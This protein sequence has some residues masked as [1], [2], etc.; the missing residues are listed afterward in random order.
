MIELSKVRVNGTN[1]DRKWELIS[2]STKEIE[3]ILFGK[4][5]VM[6]FVEK[7]KGKYMN[8]NWN[9]NPWTKI[10]KWLRKWKWYTRKRESESYPVAAQRELRLSFL[11]KDQWNL[12]WESESETNE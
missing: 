5:L 4:V 2:G 11:L 9:W 3:V 6:I 10:N 7:V 8:R 1:K 12:Y